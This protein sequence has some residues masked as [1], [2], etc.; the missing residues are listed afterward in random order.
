MR[1]VRGHLATLVPTRF[2]PRYRLAISDLKFSGFEITLDRQKLS[3]LIHAAA[4][5][6]AGTFLPVC[7][8]ARPTMVTK[9]ARREVG[10]ARADPLPVAAA[11][12]DRRL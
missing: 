10:A 3:E 11:V 4:A 1:R 6:F 8:S 7:V 2:D 5:I 12:S 9:P